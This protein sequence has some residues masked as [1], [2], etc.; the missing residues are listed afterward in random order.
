MKKTIL[1]LMFATTIQT[2]IFAADNDIYVIPSGMSVGVKLYTDGLTVAGVEKVTD[3][4]GRM[5]SP[6]AEAGIRKGDIIYSANGAPLSTVEQLAEEINKSANGVK[7]ELRR[8]C[9][10]LSITANPA[11][12]SDSAF[13]LGM[14]VRDSTAGIGTITYFQPETNTYAALG[15]GI[16]DSDTGNILTVKSGNIQQCTNL[17]VKKSERGAPGELDAVFNG[18][19][20]GEVELNSIAGI[21]GT[22]N[23]DGAVKGTP[24]KIALSSEVREGE[25]Y[26]MTDAAGNGVEYYRVDL[27][28]LKPESRDTKGIVFKIMDDRLIEATGGVVKGMSG[29]PIIQEGRLV[30]AVTHVFVNDPS[31]GYGIF[32]EN[33]LAQEAKLK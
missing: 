2:C 5:V 11:R 31:K 1:A 9:E 15:H 24:V 20:L 32:I 18:P 14:W 33:M 23:S 25:A 17:T 30:G 13:K 7:L 6:A 8:G 28:R 19:E 10:S 27:Q 12:T 3:A 29:A 16:C 4:G 26:I 21:F 22:M